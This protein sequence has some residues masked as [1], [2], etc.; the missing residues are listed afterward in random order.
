MAYYFE[1]LRDYITDN[2]PHFGDEDSV[3]TKLYEAYAD[4]NRMDDDTI[5]ED[6]RELYRLISGMELQ[7]MDRIIYPV[8][9]LCRDHQW[10]EFINGMKVGIRLER[11]PSGDGLVV[12]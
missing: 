12:I 9:N 4:N 3:L 7:E 10:S 1:K 11:E 5:K 2:P 8:H 6:F